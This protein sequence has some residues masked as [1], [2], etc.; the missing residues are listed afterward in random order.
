MTQSNKHFLLRPVKK[1]LYSFCVVGS[2]V[3]LIYS[4]ASAKKLQ[5]VKNIFAIDRKS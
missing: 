5:P 3:T 1:Q 2:Q 4:I